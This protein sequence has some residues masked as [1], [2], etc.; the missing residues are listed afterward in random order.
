MTRRRLTVEWQHIRGAKGTCQR[1]TETGDALD[2]LH[3]ELA[4]LVRP[5]QE[6]AITE[7]ILPNDA[8]HDSNRVLIN[9]TPIEEILD[10]ARVDTTS[11]TGCG[12]LDACCESDAA[13]AQCR[14]VVV[15][16][17]VHEPLSAQ[18]IREAVRKAH[19]EA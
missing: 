13:P 10:N 14:A 19:S 2:A 15:D 12:D 7:T 3:D 6:V 11:C 9:G 4:D 16:G 18:L 1:C 8:L 5:G 17:T